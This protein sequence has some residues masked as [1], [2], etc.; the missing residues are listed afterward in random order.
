ML[1]AL[2]AA[3]LEPKRLRLVHGRQGKDASL[4]LLEAKKGAAPGLRAEPPLLVY[5]QGAKVQRRG[6]GYI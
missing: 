4:A 2:G 3:G 5:G 6:G 1:A